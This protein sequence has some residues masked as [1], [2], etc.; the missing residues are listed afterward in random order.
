MHG[1]QHNRL[2]AAALTL[3]IDL[4]KHDKM[5]AVLRVGMNNDDTG[6]RCLTARLLSGRRD[7]SPDANRRLR[8]MT[9]D[10]KDFVREVVEEELESSA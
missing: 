3:K 4:T 5:I 8:R 10:P 7:L 1:H 9:A 2:T 6:I